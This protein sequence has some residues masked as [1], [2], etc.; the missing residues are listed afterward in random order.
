MTPSD[1]GGVLC[2]HPVQRLAHDV[3]TLR[4]YCTRCYGSL[5]EPLP[6]SM[7]MRQMDK[8]GV[9]PLVERIFAE[10]PEDEACAVFDRLMEDIRK[11]GAKADERRG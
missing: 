11:N 2:L 7:N 8:L 10:L 9:S 5:T 3:E 4:L 1:P 6:A